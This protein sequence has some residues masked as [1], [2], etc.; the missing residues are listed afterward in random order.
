MSAA[1]SPGEGRPLDSLLADFSAGILSRPLSVLVE[2]H[3]A[4]KPE[5]RSFVAALDAIGGGSLDGAGALPMSGREA[6][7]AAIFASD[8]P[9]PVA[10]RSVGDD[11]LPAPL[12]DFIGHGLEDVRW[13]WIMPGLREHRFADARASLLWAKPGARMPNHTHGGVEV[14]L[15]LKG[16]VTD[17]TGTYRRGDI[18]IGDETLDHRP[19]IGKDGDC[20]CFVVEEAP[21]RLTGSVGRWVEMLRPHR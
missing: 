14:T 7:L 20:I 15:V 6:R 12:H 3:L 18:E 11:V 4:L 19:L 5:S 2:T 10:P 21:L 16:S 8:E 9:Q 13:N 1:P 17:A